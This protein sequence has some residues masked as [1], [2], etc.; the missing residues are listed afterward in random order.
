MTTCPPACG[1]C[2]S[3]VVLAFTP[4]DVQRLG[5]Q[6]RRQFLSPRD[7]HWVLHELVP[8][9]RRDGIERVRDY[10]GQGGKT[11]GALD[12][13]SP[14]TVLWSHFYECI[15]FDPEART[16]GVYDD[17]P[18]ACREYPWPDGQPDRRKSLPLTC[19]YRAE[20]GKPVT[21]VAIRS[22]ERP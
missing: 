14:G 4:S 20:I 13:H 3:P 6:Q 2:C 22:K 18:D 11:V 12:A 16:C 21:P 1:A 8:L 15:H 19:S 10:M 17:R 9:R 5:P 7:E